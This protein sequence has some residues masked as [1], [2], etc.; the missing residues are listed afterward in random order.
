MMTLTVWVLIRKQ[1]AALVDLAGPRQL[2]QDWRQLQ[3]EELEGVHL[4]VEPV[5]QETRILCG[6]LKILM[7]P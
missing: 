6:R 4:L 1:V 2:R 5:L 7:K 3:V